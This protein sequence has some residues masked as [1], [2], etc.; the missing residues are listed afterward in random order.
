MEHIH[1]PVIVLA[2]PTAVGKTDLSLYLAERFNCEIIS[3][4]SM[5]VYRYMDIGTA[6]VS[7]EERRHV[8]HHLIDIR[9]PDQQYDAA[10]FVD[11]ALAA[12]ELIRQQDK[13]PLITG[14]TGLYLSSLVNGLFADT[15]ASEVTRKKIRA[16]FKE[17]GR[18]ASYAELKKVD[19][20]AASNIHPNDTQRLL[21]GLEI[22][23][24]TGT[25]WSVH[26]KKQR[27]NRARVFANMILIGLTREREQ[28]H[29][30]I[31][32]RSKNMIKH[33][34]IEEISGIIEMGY[35]PDL[36]PLQ[37]IG[38]RHGL[39]YLNGSRSQDQMIDELARDTRRYAKRQYTW[40]RQYADMSWHHPENIKKIAEKINAS[41]C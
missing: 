9:T 18:E 15:G 23:Y 8:N 16:R 35:S 40:F 38:Y 31:S 33:G 32:E 37:G 22:F 29:K 13:I 21:R 2:G 26:I 20:V 28:L 5:Q 41:L 24:T 10:S 12:M 6:K 11:D 39:H 36:P 25:P 19:P 4:D 30:R 34:L 3:M 1:Y 7:G 17:Q 14:G 27:E